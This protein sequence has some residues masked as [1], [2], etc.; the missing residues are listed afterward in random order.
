MLLRRDADAADRACAEALRLDTGNILAL[1]VRALALFALER[2]DALPQM[3]EGL[4]R[5]APNRGW[6]ALAR[7][8]YHLLRR[9]RALVAPWLEK[10]EAVGDVETLTTVAAGWLMINNATAA[11]RVFQRIL[12]A[13][14][15]NAAAEIG[16]AMVAMAKRD[17]LEAEAALRRAAS[18]EPGRAMTY[19]T[20]ARVYRETGRKS[21]AERTSEIARRLTRQ[22]L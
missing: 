14:P 2:P 8:A 17:F 9:E 21:Q 16:M 18:H 5:R 10:A 6:S 20:L 15:A 7:A 11:E 13:D 3:A 1:R 4:E 22:G 19:E 12:A